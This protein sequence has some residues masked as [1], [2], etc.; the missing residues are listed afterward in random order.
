MEIIRPLIRNMRDVRRFAAA[1]HGTA[2]TLGGRIALADLLALEAIRVFLPDVFAQIQR[3]VNGLCTPSERLGGGDRY[4]PAQRKE[5]IERLLEVAG[6][7][8]EVVRALLRRLFPFAL[9]HIENN[10]YGSDWLGTYLRERRVA[11]E[12][13]LRLYLEQVAGQKLANFYASERAWEVMSDRQALGEYLRSLSPERLEEVIS[14]L[15]AYEGEFRSEHVVPGT[16]VLLNL[17]SEI[18]DRPRG[19]YDLEPR[20]VVGR[21]TYRLLRSLGDKDDVGAAVVEILPALSS[22][23][24]KFELLTTVG[25]RE[26]AGH[27]LISEEAAKKLEAEWRAE[28][29]AAQPAD[30]AKENDL[31]QV[32]YWSG[33]DLEDDEPVIEVPADPQVTLAALRGAKTETRRQSLESRAVHRTPVFAWDSLIGIYGDE[34]TLV[35]HIEELKSSDIEVDGDLG[36]LIDKYLSGWRPKD[37]DDDD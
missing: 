22:L 10:N 34:E 15:E 33:Q 2:E 35:Q 6:D 21:V 5:S 25:Y 17:V 30:L 27:K 28:V 29:R 23:S 37:F 24:A 9:R 12:D 11:H 20:M 8:E 36:E 1:V 4:E 7:R 13:I 18:P 16:T 14:G 19:M 26:N 3:S 31:V 32:F